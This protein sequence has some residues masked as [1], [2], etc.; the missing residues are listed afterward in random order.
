MSETTTYDNFGNILTYDSGEVETEVRLK[1]QLGNLI[2]FSIPVRFRCAY[3][4]DEQGRELSYSDTIGASRYCF[5]NARGQITH[6]TS[7]DYSYEVCFDAQGNELRY[8]NSTGY[9]CVYIRDDQGRVVVC[10]N[11]KGQGYSVVYRSDGVSETE[12]IEVEAA[13]ALAV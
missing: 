6:F 13:K 4:R 1:N 8:S 10:A 11:N 2:S 7:N 9:V 12:V 3:R 5:R